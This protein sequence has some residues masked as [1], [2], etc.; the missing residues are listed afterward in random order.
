MDEYLNEFKK[1]HKSNYIKKDV[2]KFN[3]KK[4]NGFISKILFSIIFL[5]CSVIFT[6]M[7]DKN[8]LLYKEHVFNKNMPFTKI[9]SLYEK[10]FGSVLP[11]DVKD[12]A[13]FSGSVTYKA[14]EAFNEGEKLTVGSN[15]IIS[16]IGSGIVV[17]IG[18]KEGYGNTVIV[19]G[20]DGSDIW[21]GNLK[22]ISVKLYDYLDKET[23]IGEVT[24]EFLYLVIKKDDK[25]IKYED[26][27]N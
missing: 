19:Q 22:N 21:Y 25:F 3:N 7:N 14:I 17:F 9:K 11:T 12:K 15:S 5:L 13:V 18:E 16:N 6:N 2:T 8:M 27:K 4:I 24:N 10:V 26:Y 20:I 1:K 23:V